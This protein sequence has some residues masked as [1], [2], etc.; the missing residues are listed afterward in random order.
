L[1]APATPRRV[2]IDTDPG[3]DDA[4]AILYALAC[5]RFE[6]LGLTTVAGNIG[7]EASTSNSL[8]LLAAM[9]RSD[10]PVRRGAAQPLCRA[11]E[12]LISIH[13]EDGMGGLALP[14]PQA[15]ARGEAVGWLVEQL[16]SAPAG[17]VDILALGPLTN[18]ALLVRDHPAVA[19]RIGRLIVMGGAVDEPG[20]IGARSEYN[21][22]ADPEA[23]QIVL[24]ARL[25]LTLIPLDVTRRV[26]VLPAQIA[27]LRS[28]PAGD[29]CAEILALYFGSGR[30]SRPLHD[31]CV[32]L[33]AVEP[34][35]FSLDTLR[36][37]VDVSDGPEAGALVRHA[38]G[39]PIK[40]AM[41]VDGPGAIEAL[42]H[43]LNRAQRSSC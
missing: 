30:A 7:I 10:V 1:S 34:G 19:A 18:I 40:V 14:A 24:E 41:R 4:V 42:R 33:F 35:L 27:S 11:G 21:F 8:R 17:S 13:G 37:A 31:P 26:R 39:P 3:L 29:L 23:A 32:M 6:V 36:L 28:S 38:D 9:A 5:G 43:G 12:E 16:Q 2:I 20:N 22:A 15:E 25:D